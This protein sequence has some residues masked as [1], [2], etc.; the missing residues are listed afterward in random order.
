MVTLQNGTYTVR[1]CTSDGSPRSVINGVAITW[2]NVPVCEKQGS[3]DY[4]RKPTYLTNESGAFIDGALLT[5]VSTGENCVSLR[6]KS[7]SVAEVKSSKDTNDPYFAIDY[8]RFAPED[9][10]QYKA[11]VVKFRP[12]ARLAGTSKLGLLYACG[13]DKGFSGTRHASYTFENNG[14]WQYAVFSTVSLTG[15]NG[16]LN[17]IRID[18]YDAGTVVP[19]GYTF[20]IG[21]VALCKSITEI[22][23]A[24][25][26]IPPKD[27]I[28]YYLC[29]QHDINSTHTVVSTG[30]L[31]PTC[32]EYGHTAGSYCSV[33]NKIIAEETVLPPLGHS[34]SDGVCTRCKE[35]DPDAILYTLTV[36]GSVTSYRA[37]DTVTVSQSVGFKLV[38]LVACRFTGWAGDTDVLSDASLAEVSFTMPGRNI[39]LS[40]VYSP[41]GDANGDGRVNAADANLIKRMILGEISYESIADI[42]LDGRVNAADANYIKRMITGSYIPEM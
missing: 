20:E 36:D 32:T 5:E 9:A 22:R 34:Y 24:R 10:Y 33:C 6:P 40:S 18:P 25:K 8:S 1:N 26:D 13:S 29:Y 14:Q 23:D 2:N 38:D 28:G 4:I 31:A 37:G 15:W 35:V 12:D 27:S 42:N 21:F 7:V 19:Y 41:V 3:L 17:S 11:V 39:T 30:A 16:Q